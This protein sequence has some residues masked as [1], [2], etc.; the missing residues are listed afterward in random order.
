MRMEMIRMMVIVTRPVMVMSMVVAMIVPMVVAM[1]VPMMVAMIVFVM[2][3]AIVSAR[4]AQVV[5]H[6]TSGPAGME[7]GLSMMDLWEPILP[8]ETRVPRTS[9]MTLVANRAVMSDVS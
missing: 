4:G 5:H 1:I 3:L 7:T 6:A 9:T 2:M 8:C